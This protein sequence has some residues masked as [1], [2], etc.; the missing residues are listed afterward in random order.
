[1]G[2]WAWPDEIPAVL[3]ENWRSIFDTRFNGDMLAL[4]LPLR[5]DDIGEN[6]RKR[7]RNQETCVTFIQFDGLAEQ[8]RILCSAASAKTVLN[9]YEKTKVSLLW[10]AGALIPEK[11]RGRFEAA[12]ISVQD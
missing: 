5:Q 11:Y 7:H 2:A 12:E 10:L 3:P 6:S 4:N 1:M 9:F 8:E